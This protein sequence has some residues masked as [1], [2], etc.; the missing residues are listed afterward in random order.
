MFKQ[1]LC[2]ILMTIG[3]SGLGFA[4]NLNSK[5]S[6]ACPPSGTSLQQAESQGWCKYLGVPNNPLE[7][8]DTQ[9]KGGITYCVYAGSIPGANMALLTYCA[10]AK[11]G[12]SN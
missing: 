1:L 9:T 6:S 11:K 8:K 3:L 5:L 12:G 4:A 10:E 7:Y 2:L